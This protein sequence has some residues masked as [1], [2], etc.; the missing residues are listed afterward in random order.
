VLISLGLSKESFTGLLDETIF[1]FAC[2]FAVAAI[3]ATI[4]FCFSYADRVQRL[5]GQGG[6]DIA[7]RLFAFILFCLGGSDSL[8][9]SELLRSIQVCPVTVVAPALNVR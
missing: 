3:A 9:R 4:F 1:V 8:V 2:L 6:I 7:A 5:L